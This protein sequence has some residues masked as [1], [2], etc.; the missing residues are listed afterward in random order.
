MDGP[1][2]QQ[3]V[4]VAPR[5]LIRTCNK[6]KTPPRPKRPPTSWEHLKGVKPLRNQGSLQVVQHIRLPPSPKRKLPRVGQKPKRNPPPPIKRPKLL[7]GS[8]Q[9][10][11]A[12]ST[13]PARLN[14]PSALIDDQNAGFP[15]VPFFEDAGM[16]ASSPQASTSEEEFDLAEAVSQIEAQ[17]ALQLP[18]YRE[19]LFWNPESNARLT[20]RC[21]IIQDWC[22]RER[23][24]LVR[25][26]Y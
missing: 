11:S 12:Q 21:Y 5:P 20:N 9:S 25:V 15:S 16:G 17:Q 13:Y 26:A 8:S 22:P 6:L 23:V 14:I 3:R 4:H 7:S 18:A 19:L 10:V 24:L 1:Q 2:P